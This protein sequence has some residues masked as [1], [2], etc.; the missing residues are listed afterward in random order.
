MLNK[1]KNAIIIPEMGE[2]FNINYSH[3][4]TLRNGDLIGVCNI[5][6]YLRKKHNKRIKF[7]IGD[8]ALHHSDY[9]LK[10]RK[11]LIE[12]T[13]YL[14]GV[15]GDQPLMTKFNPI[16]V[17]CMRGSVGDHVRIDI[18]RIRTT[19]ICIFPIFDAPYNVYRNWNMELT[20]E[21]IDRFSEPEY[22]EYEKVFCSLYDPVNINKREFAFSVDFLD[23][24]NH[25]LTCSH[26][27]GGDTGMSH[28]AGALDD[29]PSLHYYMYSKGETFTL[30][31]HFT[32]KGEMNLYGG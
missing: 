17:W 16:S 23:N 28:F 25:I 19:K 7:F 21:I 32:R 9:C 20:Q 27:V 30:P 6:E 1:F 29:G 22:D 31:F 10:F 11:F 12:N 3:F 26:Y 2:V 5:I 8:D 4:N 13:D 18:P 15:P 14:S 24:I